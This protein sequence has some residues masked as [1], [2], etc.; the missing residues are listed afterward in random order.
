MDGYGSCVLCVS[1]VYFH[2]V[3]VVRSS[4][5]RARMYALNPA[6]FD[7]DFVVHTDAEGAK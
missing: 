4:S 2:V 7:H 6:R 5:R 3:V 1:D